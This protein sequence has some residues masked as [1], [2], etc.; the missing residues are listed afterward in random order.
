MIVFKTYLQSAIVIQREGIAGVCR[1]PV[2]VYS[3]GDDSTVVLV[4][5]RL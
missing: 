4:V 3:V 1:Q 5:G 2:I